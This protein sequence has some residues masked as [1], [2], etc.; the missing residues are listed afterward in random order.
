MLRKKEET[1]L[2]EKIIKKSTKI[3]KFRNVFLEQ[4]RE[5]LQ[6]LKLK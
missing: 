4:K 2:N 5:I 3:F 1:Q 6:L